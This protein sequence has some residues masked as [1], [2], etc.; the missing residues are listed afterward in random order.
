LQFRPAGLGAIFAELLR[1][2]K[3]VTTGIVNV[4]AVVGQK[5]TT[6]NEPLPWTAKAIKLFQ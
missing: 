5:T 4:E 2:A 1:L 6:W 3:I